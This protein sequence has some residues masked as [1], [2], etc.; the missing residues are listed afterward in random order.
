MS[1]EECGTF[2]FAMKR[3]SVVVEGTISGCLF[4]TYV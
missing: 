4:S 1:V 2:H 3:M